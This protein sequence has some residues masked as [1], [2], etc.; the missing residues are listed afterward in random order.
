MPVLCCS[1]VTLLLFVTGPTLRPDGTP[2]GVGMN[3]ATKIESRWDFLLKTVS[4]KEL[5]F[6]AFTLPSKM[7]LFAENRLAEEASTPE[8]LLCLRFRLSA[9][10][11]SCEILFSDRQLE[12]IDPPGGPRRHGEPPGGFAV[13]R[14]PARRSTRGRF[15][16]TVSRLE[17]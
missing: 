3:R 16:K 2:M 15:C 6:R 7:G 4:P 5:F 8:R 12:V 1:F 9:V 10:S 13:F 14:K 17:L 11:G